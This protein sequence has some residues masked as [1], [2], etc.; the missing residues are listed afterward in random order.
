MNRKKNGT[1]VTDVPS[2]R[3]RFKLIADENKFIIDKTDTNDDGKYS[4]EFDGVSK[5]IEVIGT[6]WHSIEIK[7]FPLTDRLYDPQPAL[8]YECLQIQPLWRVKKMSVTCSVVGTKPELT[9]TFG[10]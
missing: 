4:C 2:L 6:Y 5:E 1:A 7:N 8:L 3:G 9:W 10:E